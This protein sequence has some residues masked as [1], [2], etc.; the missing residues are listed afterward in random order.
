LLGYFGLEATMVLPT[1]LI[2][3]IIPFYNRE[4]F[5]GESLDSV[6]KQSY[7][8]IEI[9]AVDDGS[10]D[11]SAAVVTQFTTP[12]LR[13]LYQEN[14]GAGAARNY[15]IAKSKGDFF[16]FLDSDDLW[17]EDKLSLQMEVFSKMEHLDMVFGHVLQF[18]SP[19][20]S[21]T[22]TIEDDFGPTPGYILGTMLIRRESFHRVGDFSTNWRLGEFIDWYA[23]AEEVA[24]T[25]HM[26]PEVVLK[27]RIHDSNLGIQ[28]RRSRGDY[29][30]IVKSIL[31]R[32]KDR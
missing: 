15:G 32:R 29:A 9:I 1:N 26:L 11:G 19:E 12:R 17:S 4:R 23:R 16:A 14:G 13:Y 30:Q 6:L 5:L 28:E 18:T 27:R 25:S 24:L 8:H 10:T 31:E 20:I 2:S 7:Q 21:Q 3:V 22:P